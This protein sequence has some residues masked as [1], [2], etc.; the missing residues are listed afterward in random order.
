MY[1]TATRSGCSAVQIYELDDEVKSSTLEVI[2]SKENV[3]NFIETLQAL[4][5]PTYAIF[6]CADL[7]S[8]GWEDRCEYLHSSKKISPRIFCSPK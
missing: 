5:F 2:R 8:T 3:V 6:S 1:L 4:Q 7:E